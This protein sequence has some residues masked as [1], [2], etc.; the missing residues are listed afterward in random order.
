MTYALPAQL[1]SALCEYFGVRDYSVLR[2]F[3]RAHLPDRRLV[4]GNAS[5]CLRATHH[6]RNV[7]PTS[8]LLTGCPGIGGA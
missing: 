6:R 3:Q 1:H 8:Y 2:P 5:G 4:G 7:A